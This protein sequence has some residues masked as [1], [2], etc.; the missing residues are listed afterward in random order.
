M[1][2]KEKAKEL[3]QKAYDL[4]QHNKTTQSR[5]KQIALLC[6]DEIEL[7]RKQIEDEYD[8]DLYHAYGVEEYWQEVRQE[9]SLL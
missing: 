3:M 9:I 7:Y 1:T 4:D 5:C 2:P 6:L 8:E